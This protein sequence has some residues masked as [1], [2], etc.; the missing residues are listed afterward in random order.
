[1]IKVLALAAVA[2]TASVPNDK[3]VVFYNAANKPVMAVP[4]CLKD[5]PAKD[6]SNV[7]TFIEACGIYFPGTIEVEIKDAKGKPV[8]YTLGQAKILVRAAK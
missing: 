4:E 1:M 2:A 6:L 3:A 5:T 8:Y 7:A